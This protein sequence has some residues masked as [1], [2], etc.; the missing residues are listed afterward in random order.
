[1]MPFSMLWPCVLSL[2]LPLSAPYFQ[3]SW[4][5]TT[6]TRTPTLVML[7]TLS[8]YPVRMC[9]FHL[10]YSH[11]QCVC[12]SRTCYCC[13]SIRQA[14]A[15]LAWQTACFPFLS[16]SHWPL[17]LLFSLIPFHSSVPLSVHLSVCAS[18]SSS[19]HLLL[20]SF[21]AFTGSSE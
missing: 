17:L 1:M 10:E 20:D 14:S 19:F 21:H 16:L 15:I 7:A 8:H 11:L 2:W 4:T 5:D 6:K 3:R 12:V 18:S 9:L 13:C